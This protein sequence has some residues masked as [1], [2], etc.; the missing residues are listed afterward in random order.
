VE[1]FSTPPSL[2]VTR[3]YPKSP[4]QS[5]RRV[6]TNYLFALDRDEALCLRTTKGIDIPL[7]LAGQELLSFL[8]EGR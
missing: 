6:P 5:S 3:L 1:Y 4:L 7:E 2:K 8:I